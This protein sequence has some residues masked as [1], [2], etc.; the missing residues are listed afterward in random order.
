MWN[1]VGVRTLA[2]I[3]LLAPV[4]AA[5]ALAPGFGAAEV[6]IRPRRHADAYILARGEHVWSTNC[7][8]QDLR[9]M[10]RKLSGTFLWF[11]RGGDAYVVRD[12]A[13]LE[14][15]W[16]LFAPLD[17]LEPERAELRERQH[18]LA[19]KE[20]ALEKEEAA[21]DRIGDRLSDADEDGPKGR[22]IENKKRVLEERQ[23]EIDTLQRP[24]DERER[25][26]DAREEV[27]ERAAEA[28]LWRLLDRAVSQ[29]I[30]QPAR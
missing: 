6:T 21:L 1:R 19:E 27:I 10:R 12:R 5:L 4:L 25:T 20:R 11:R 26:L 8:M 23:R 7:S 16:S 24:E 9:A 2:P 29:G 3:R 30:A 18:R 22:E 13:T 28:E 15:A 17:A 14:A